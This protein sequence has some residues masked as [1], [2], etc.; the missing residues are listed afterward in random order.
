MSWNQGLKPDAITGK[1]LFSRLLGYNLK[2]L[3]LH[4]KVALTMK[5]S[6]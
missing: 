1:N 2:N 5:G 3:N 4:H 6:I